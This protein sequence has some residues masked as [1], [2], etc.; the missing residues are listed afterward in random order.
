[1]IDLDN[2][3][4]INEVY[5]LEAGNKVLL[6]LVSLIKNIISSQGIIARY[7]G[8]EF[9][10]LLPETNIEQ[11]MEIAGKICREVESYDFSKFTSGKR[12][13]VTTSIGISSF[14]E[15]ANDIIA[16]K[17]KADKALYKAKESGRNRAMY[18]E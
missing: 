12:I 4:T 8:D 15:T 3:R 16:F 13:A 18:I 10:V 2:F 11:A 5:G 6:V 1:M 17:E 9:S 14:P 7:G